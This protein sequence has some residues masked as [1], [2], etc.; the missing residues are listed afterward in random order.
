M[1]QDTDKE[2]SLSAKAE[3]AFQQAAAKVIQRARQT[4][5]PV[6]IWKAGRVEKIPSDRFE[7]TT[8]QGKPENRN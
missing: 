1:N 3:A 6:V 8:I 7:T 5:T 4:G 2:L